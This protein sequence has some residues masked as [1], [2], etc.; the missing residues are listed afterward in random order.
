MKERKVFKRD[1][2]SQDGTWQRPVQ[3]YR[4]AD[5]LALET[6][7]GVEFDETQQQLVLSYM[8]N[9]RRPQQNTEPSV[10]RFQI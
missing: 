10:A 3:V 8:F 1:T 2:S 5:A 4:K 6:G 9:P 7:T